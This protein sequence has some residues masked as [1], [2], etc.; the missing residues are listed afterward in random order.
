MT[1][2]SPNI[3]TGQNCTYFMEMCETVSLIYTS[4]T[5]THKINFTFCLLPYKRNLVERSEYS[6][7]AAVATYHGELAKTFFFCPSSVLSSLLG[8]KLSPRYIWQFLMYQQ[9]LMSLCVWHVLQCTSLNT[10]FS[11]EKAVTFQEPNE[12]N[13]IELTKDEDQ[14]LTKEDALEPEDGPLD[15][16][17]EEAVQLERK[18]AEADDGEDNALQQDDDEEQ[19]TVQSNTINFKK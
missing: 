8:S 12:P 3:F 19:T 1:T 9:S 14:L 17:Q 5:Y 4:Q 7:T 11:L 2:S 10:E 18:L 15:M 13:G 6:Q 16:E